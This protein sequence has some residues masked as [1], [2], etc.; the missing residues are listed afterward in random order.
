MTSFL[1]RNEQKLSREFDINGYIVKDISDQSSL[2]KIKEIFLKSIKKNLKS[3]NH[4]FK[5]EDEFFNFIHKK[6]RPNE[7]NS[8]R[9]KII[10]EINA[11]K[12]VRKLYYQISRDYLDILVGNELS[13]QLRVNL[14]IQL[15]KDN[16]SLLLYIQMY[17]RATHHLKQLYGYL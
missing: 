15:P 13:M 17:G 3:K 5:S 6:I 14:S 12:E 16:S 9:M 1:S 11:N 7:L 4:N 8:F 10:N 2:K